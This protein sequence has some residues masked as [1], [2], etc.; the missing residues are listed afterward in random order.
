MADRTSAYLF[1]QVF[2]HLAAEPITDCD[3]DFAQY[4]WALTQDYDFMDQQ[5]ECDDVLV[6]LGLAKRV[7]PTEDEPS[8]IVYLEAVS[9]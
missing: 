9:Q 7:E 2:E 5:L 3:R 1:T 8:G 4:M 6:A